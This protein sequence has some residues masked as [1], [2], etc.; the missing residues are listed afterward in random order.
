ME[1]CTDHN[2]VFL[3]YFNAQ[4]FL[5][6][7]AISHLFLKLL[8]S[9]YPFYFHLLEKISSTFLF[10]PQIY[11]HPI[12]SP[13]LSGTS[14]FFL[15][16]KLIW[17]EKFHDNHASF[18]PWVLNYK[19]NLFSSSPGTHISSSTSIPVKVLKIYVFFYTSNVTTL[20]FIENILLFQ[21]HC[22]SNRLLKF[23]FGV[24]DYY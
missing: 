7:Y 1:S 23:T 19:K 16:K 11:L 6:S 12:K 14:V 3:L 4:Q 2:P 10:L 24:Y 13:Y 21:P 8:S 15:S 17:S 20:L 9:S 5:V 22:E 18:S